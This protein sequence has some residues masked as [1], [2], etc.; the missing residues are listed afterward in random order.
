MSSNEGGGGSLPNENMSAS[1]GRGGIAGAC[2]GIGGGGQSGAL[3][4][5]T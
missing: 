2:F 5:D 1:C 4:T 3:E